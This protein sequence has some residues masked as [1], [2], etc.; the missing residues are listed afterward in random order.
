MRE[1]TMNE[2]Q[3]VTGGTTTTCTKTETKVCN[4][5]ETRCTTLSVEVC[6]KK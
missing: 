3:T 6:V 1:L 5:N 2:V 4:K